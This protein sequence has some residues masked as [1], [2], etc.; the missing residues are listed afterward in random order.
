M[1]LAAVNHAKHMN[2]ELGAFVT[3]DTEFLLRKQQLSKLIGTPLL[4]PKEYVDAL[5]LG[6]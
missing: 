6:R 2:S 1:H 3:G 5:G 4:S